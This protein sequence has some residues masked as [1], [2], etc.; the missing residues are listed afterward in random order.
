MT[1]RKIIITLTTLAFVLTLAAAVPAK[2]V[3]TPR[4]AK[5]H[6]A[7]AAPKKTAAPTAKEKH[8]PGYKKPKAV[9]SR[10]R[11]KHKPKAKKRAKKA[12][13]RG[14]GKKRAGAHM[15]TPQEIK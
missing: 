13:K 4:Q 11:T 12:A 2:V 15:I 3:K 5:L 1:V 6:N 14:K 9:K 10:H 7:K 8:K